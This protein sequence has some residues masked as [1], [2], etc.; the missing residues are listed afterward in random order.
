MRRRVLLHGLTLLAAPT[1]MTG[2]D[3]AVRLGTPEVESLKTVTTAFRQLDNAHGGAHTR[4]AVADYLNR[5]AVPMLTGQATD[6]VRR[7][8]YSAVAEL[9]QLAGWTAY[10]S[11]MHSI[12]RRQLDQAREWAE[13]ASDR[14]LVAE[15]YAAMSHQA[16]F[17]GNGSEAVA[18]A[19]AALGAAVSGGVR[20]LVAEARMAA[21]HGCAVQGNANESARLLLLAEQTLDQADR[22]GDPEWISYFGPAYLAAKTGWC[23]LAV[24]DTGNAVDAAEK[25]LDMDESFVRGRMF[26]LTLLASSLI[27]AG[28]PEQA[29][30]HGAEAAEIAS[31]L[32]SARADE[33]LRRVAVALA[34]YRDIPQARD[35]IVGI[36]AR[37][38]P[39]Q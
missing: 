15:I 23:M 10:D 6:V 30:V 28:H 29:C 9:A 31:D 16:A 7:R 14:P 2:V 5:Q 11:G 26:N 3:A 38:S 8:L 33:Y 20:A 24:G 25:S 35:L 22:D 17:L 32:R 12:A 13:S 37:L 34:P 36:G 19:D 39:V 21:A 1:A 4:E 18:L 27:Q